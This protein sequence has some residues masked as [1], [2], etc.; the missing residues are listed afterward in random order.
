MI[1]A[2]VH[3]VFSRSQASF[4]HFKSIFKLLT[5]L[6][7]IQLADLQTV[8]SQKTIRRRKF[9]QICAWLAEDVKKI[10]NLNVRFVEDQ[11]LPVRLLDVGISEEAEACCASGNHEKGPLRLV[12]TKDAEY[13]Q[14]PISDDAR[15]QHHN[16]LNPRW[17]YYAA[18]SHRWGK[19][20]ELS[21]TTKENIK[22]RFQRIE[23]SQLCRTFQDAIIVARELRIRYLWIDS[24]CII[25][26][27]KDDWKRESAVMGDVYYKSFVTLFAHSYAQ[28]NSDVMCYRI[29]ETE[30]N[31]PTLSIK[32][33]IEKGKA[34]A[35]FHDDGGSGFLDSAFRAEGDSP[36]LLGSTTTKLG[37]TQNYLYA[38][39]QRM[40]EVDIQNSGLTSRGW[41]VQERLL[42]PRI[43]HFFHSQ[44]FYES[45]LNG[46]VRAEDRTPVYTDPDQLR[47][48]IFSFQTR[49]GST[50]DEWFK[51]VERF[52]ACQLTKGSDKLLAI[53]GIAEKFHKESQVNYFAGLFADRVA[54][55]LLWIRR[56]PN[57]TRV[58]DRAPSWSWASVDGPI[59]YPSLLLERPFRVLQEIKVDYSITN[60]GQEPKHLKGL[61]N[62]QFLIARGFM[63]NI[64]LGSEFMHKSK[65][66]EYSPLPN[67]LPYELDNDSRY[68]KLLNDDGMN[69]GWASLDE[70]ECVFANVDYSAAIIASE[71]AWVVND[72]DPLNI[73]YRTHPLS[74]EFE[75]FAATKDYAA[76]HERIKG[77]NALA[78][79]LISNTVDHR[80]LAMTYWVLILKAESFPPEVYTP[81]DSTDIMVNWKRVG[82]GQIVEKTWLRQSDFGSFYL[83]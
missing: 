48:Y 65:I 20:T 58:H 11:D 38:K 2:C 21:S 29:V 17:V 78:E 51:V 22:S 34:R 24:L 43:V 52:C 46:G 33:G 26:D 41:V 80:T 1:I 8:Q 73:L 59:H 70:D 3:S 12:H 5:F 49:F 31:E 39:R 7:L 19:S 57:L 4:D 62:V 63:R 18:L 81:D 68:R 36:V 83:G 50:P 6:D 37:Q 53:G 56:G 28:Q 60:P 16:F 54:K 44:L 27:D 69:I 40:F 55:G 13:G 25:Q 15:W 9:D 32:S 35:S 77:E 71:E 61:D 45:K 79:D 14:L 74:R 23:Y 72:S 82:L 75:A 42:S 30:C 76:E 67:I 64:S 66:L 10:D 47:E